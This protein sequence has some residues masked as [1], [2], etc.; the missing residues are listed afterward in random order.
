MTSK[1]IYYESVAYFLE[2]LE[3]PKSNF[4][5]FAYINLKDLHVPKELINLKVT[6]EFYCIMFNKA[7]NNLRYGVQEYNLQS[8]SLAFVAPNQV[9]EGTENSNSKKGWI[10]CFSPKFLKETNLLN[11]LDRFNLFSYELNTA[12][13]L[14]PELEKIIHSCAERIANETTINDEFSKGIICSELELILRYASRTLQKQL[15]LKAITKTN[16]IIVSIEKILENYFSEELQLTYG[17]PKINY[18]SDCL[19]FSDKYLSN[20]IYKITG[21][22]TTDYINQFVINKSKIKILSTTKTI[23][24]IAYEMGF[25]QPHYFIK[26]FKKYNNVTPKAYRELHQ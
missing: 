8:G 15:Q 16:D 9:I 1:T 22:K 5:D 17:I 6:C 24:E 14:N 4:T 7:P 3:Q 10:L 23:Q 25:T 2:K 26:L 18:L 11:T 20:L 13:E 12:L 19:N 21:I